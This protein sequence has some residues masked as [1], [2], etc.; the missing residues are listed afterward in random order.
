LKIDQNPKMNSNK[1]PNNNTGT[2]MQT[3]VGSTL[4]EA[5]RATKN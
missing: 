2:T 3:R 4:G 1:K 5:R